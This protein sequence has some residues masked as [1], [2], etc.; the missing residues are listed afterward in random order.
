MLSPA[1]SICRPTTLFVPVTISL[2]ALVPVG[3][4]ELKEATK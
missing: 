1:R 4:V 2:S 3:M